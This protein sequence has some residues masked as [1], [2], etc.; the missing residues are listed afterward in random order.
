MKKMNIITIQWRNL[1]R[2]KG[3][4]WWWK[5]SADT[6]CYPLHSALKAKS[7]MLVFFS[8]FHS[9]CL[10]SYKNLLFF[11]EF[12][13]KRLLYFIEKKILL[14]YL[15]ID[16]EKKHHRLSLFSLFSKKKIVV[17]KTRS[18]WLDHYFARIEQKKTCCLFYVLHDNGTQIR[19]ETHKTDDRF[20]CLF[21]NKSTRYY[22]NRFRRQ[23]KI[24]RIFRNFKGSIIK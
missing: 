10:V 2:M 22:V 16:P 17:P 12:F 13:K 21:A 5:K 18:V 6:L 8:I 11:S 19:D 20:I 7:F 23:H 3:T 24:D 1:K 15:S 14:I 4:Q 9:S